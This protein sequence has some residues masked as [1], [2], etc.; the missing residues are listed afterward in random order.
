MGGEDVQK[1]VLGHLHSI[2]GALEINSTPE[3]LQE[4]LKELRALRNDVASIQ[5]D[6]STIERNTSG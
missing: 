5:S 4:I 3:A 1:E 2:V 6:V